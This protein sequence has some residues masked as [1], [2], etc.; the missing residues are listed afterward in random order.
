[1]SIKRTNSQ[2][3]DFQKLVVLLDQ[4]LKNKD[5]DE[6]SFFSQY[7]KLDDIKNVVVYYHD[8]IPVG[9][10]AFKHYDATT[11]E[12]K[13][14]FVL[15]EVRGKGIAY[16]ILQELEDW[17]LELGYSE[18]ILETGQKM[19]EAIRLYE[20]AGYH[21]IPNYGQYENVESSVCMRKVCQKNKK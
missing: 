19:I 13:R 17:A 12:I 20:K 7:N 16:K 4:D 18:Y 21:R 3:S 1:M 8:S 14:M 5:G 9:C 2:D 15:P 11:V 10:G 6:H